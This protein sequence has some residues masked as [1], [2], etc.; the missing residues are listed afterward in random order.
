M[1]EEMRNIRKSKGLTMKQLGDLVGVAEATISTYENGRSEP[2]LGVLCSIA[3]ALDVSLDML[4]RGKEKDRPHGRS[5]QEIMEEYD[6]MSESEL[7]R[8]ISI[9]S[10]LSADKQFH[11][12]RHSDGKA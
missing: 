2:T 5:M 4:I 1:L 6:S 9:L 7:N 11:A 10:A 12:H 8:L 3:D